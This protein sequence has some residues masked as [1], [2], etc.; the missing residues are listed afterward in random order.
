MATSTK[1]SGKFAQ[2]QDFVPFDG[3][4]PVRN[5]LDKLGDK[6]TTLIL[7]ALAGGARRFSELNRSVPDIS[8]R[9]LTTTLRDLERDGLIA[10]RVYPTKPPSVDYRLTPLGLTL[11]E[12]VAVLIDW[13]ER[14]HDDIWA[15]RARFDETGHGASM[16]IA[17]E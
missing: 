6:W 2:W 9:M 4:C 3:D 7:M 13:A 10:R 8:K 16:A 5:V 17:A 15:A 12:P 14:S 1:L 11:L